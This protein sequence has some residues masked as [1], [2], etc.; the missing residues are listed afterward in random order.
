MSMPDRKMSF[1]TKLP[2]SFVNDKNI[3]YLSNM[4]IV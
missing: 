1:V 4:T 3:F 2:S